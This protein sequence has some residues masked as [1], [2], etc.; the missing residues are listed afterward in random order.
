M[1]GLDTL[2]KLM[3]GR[4][5]NSALSAFMR[6]ARKGRNPATGEAIKSAASKS[7]MFSAGATLNAAVNPKKK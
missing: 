3:G 7:P 6:A 1:E 2:S 4:K 5:S